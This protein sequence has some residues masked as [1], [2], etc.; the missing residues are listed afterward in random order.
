MPVC[1]QPPRVRPAHC[2]LDL[3]S[4]SPI[5]LRQRRGHAPV[6]NLRLCWSEDRSHL[7]DVEHGVLLEFSHRVVEVVDG[8]TN[9]RRIGVLALYGAG[10]LTVRLAQLSFTLL[11][12]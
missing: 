9:L 7:K 4:G 11:P 3:Q 12:A 1:P 5:G 10:Q 8:G 6:E 2:R